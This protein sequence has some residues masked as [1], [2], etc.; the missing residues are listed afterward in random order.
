[1]I[2]NIVHLTN[3][4]SQCPWISLKKGNPKNPNMRRAESGTKVAWI[5]CSRHNFSTTLSNNWSFDFDLL[6]VTSEFQKK[7]DISYTICLIYSDQSLKNL[8]NNVSTIVAPGHQN[9]S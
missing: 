4:Q 7:V 1:M 2:L 9:N 6:S 8:S 5:F 3:K